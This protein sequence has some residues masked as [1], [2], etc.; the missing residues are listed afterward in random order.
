[1]LAE[2]AVSSGQCRAQQNRVA[3]LRIVQYRQAN[4]YTYGH[5]QDF[6]TRYACTE[7]E[8]SNLGEKP[9]YSMDSF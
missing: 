4:M 5:V 9:C 8:I 1:M 6:E 7:S 2:S 3:Q